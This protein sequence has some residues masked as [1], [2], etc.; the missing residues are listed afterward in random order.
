MLRLPLSSNI[1]FCLKMVL[2]STVQESV[3]LMKTYAVVMTVLLVFLYVLSKNVKLGAIKQLKPCSSFLFNCA[4]YLNKVL[5]I[6]ACIMCIVHTT[7]ILAVGL[8][9]NKAREESKALTFKW[10][11]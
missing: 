6:F 1:C 8:I 3:C 9:D 11:C 7:G 2:Q 10:V 4:L 5:L